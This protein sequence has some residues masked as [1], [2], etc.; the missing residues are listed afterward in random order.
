MVY[1][2]GPYERV[3]DAAAKG[4]RKAIA[5]SSY[6]VGEFARAWSA[7]LGVRHP[8]PW[9]SV[10]DALPPALMAIGLKAGDEVTAPA[11]A[12]VAPADTCADPQHLHELCGTRLAETLQPPYDLAGVSAAHDTCRMPGEAGFRF[13]AKP[14]AVL[15]GLKSI[16]RH[17]IYTLRYG[18]F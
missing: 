10:T 16:Y 15:A 12:Y 18:S 8:I 13:I 11:F 17:T 9:G 4:A 5:M 14:G 6:V 7:G 3:R 2:R 1:F